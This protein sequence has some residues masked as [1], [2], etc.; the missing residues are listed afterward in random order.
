[1]IFKNIPIWFTLIFV[2]PSGEWNKDL[3]NYQLINPTISIEK[4]KKDEENPWTKRTPGHVLLYIPPI[5]AKEAANEG[6]TGM[7][8]KQD[9][10][11]G[12][13]FRLW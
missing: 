5:I 2:S 6:F 12:P 9:H 11:L 10:T 8:A 7:E 1:M 13:F 3:V 4:G